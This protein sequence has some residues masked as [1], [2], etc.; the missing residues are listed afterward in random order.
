MAVSWYEKPKSAE[1]PA[2]KTSSKAKKVKIVWKKSKEIESA[3]FHFKCICQLCRKTD[4]SKEAW[5][6][7]KP[8]VSTPIPP[9]KVE[10][11]VEK[12]QAKV[13]ATPKKRSVKPVNKPSIQSKN[14]LLYTSDAADE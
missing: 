13:V 9:R 2:K 4:A 10:V 7:K 12:P 11:R 8:S 1:Q 3:L 14:C 5:K 6:A